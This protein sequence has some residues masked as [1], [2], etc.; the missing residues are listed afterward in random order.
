MMKDSKL[1]WMSS[2]SGSPMASDT[3]EKM[4]TTMEMTNSMVSIRVVRLIME[5]AMF[6]TN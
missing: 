6:L 1:A 3:R 4:V 5:W 2:W